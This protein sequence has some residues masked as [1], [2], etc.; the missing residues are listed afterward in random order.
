MSNP[1]LDSII[2]ILESNAR[3]LR[4]D[5]EDTLHHILIIEDQIGRLK[6]LNDTNTKPKINTSEDS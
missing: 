5:V 3:G 6:E 4:E 2:D 1:T